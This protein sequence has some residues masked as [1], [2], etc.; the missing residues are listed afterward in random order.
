MSTDLNSLW[1]AIQRRDTREIA[2][3]II[4]QTRSN[5]GT[6]LAS[7]P[8]KGLPTAGIGTADAGILSG[9]KLVISQYRQA[10]YGYERL[11]EQLY[12]LARADRFDEL[13][14]AIRAE[15]LAIHGPRV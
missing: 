13:H 15:Y 9:D 1:D 5:P 6:V 11:I 8:Q 2:S 4:P 7:L 10:I 3:H 12:D 14:D